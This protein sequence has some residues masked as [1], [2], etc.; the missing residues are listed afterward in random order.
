MKAN[1]ELFIDPKLLPAR[2]LLDTGVLIRAL[3]DRP[4][5]A[6]AAAAKA[7][8][9]AMVEQ[10][11]EM[12]VG[13]PSVAEM[14]RGPVKTRVPRISGIAVVAFDNRA[15]EL[16]AERMPHRVLIRVRDALN[17]PLDYM[18]YDAL[19]VASAIRW[20]ADAIIS[21]DKGVLRLAE[22]VS[23]RAQK[24]D[25]FIAKQGVLPFG[26]EGGPSADG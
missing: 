13:A 2:A 6:N 15:A 23:A 20:G 9:E 1:S 12:L 26:S 3:G 16:L 18:R 24:P 19:L 4:K 5:D 7:F 17:V 8:F 11:R 25:E 14:L 22:A 10:R 21:L